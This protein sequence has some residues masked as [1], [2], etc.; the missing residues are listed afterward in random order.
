MKVFLADD[1]VTTVTLLKILLE[2]EGHETITFPP[3]QPV[4]E[5]IRAARPDVLVLDLHLPEGQNGLDILQALRQEE[6][7]QLRKMKVIVCSGQDRRQEVMQA[8]A[9]AFLLKPYMPDDLLQVIRQDG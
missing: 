5:A 7:E 1:D 6:D 4:L 9:D 2:M 8:G 3:D